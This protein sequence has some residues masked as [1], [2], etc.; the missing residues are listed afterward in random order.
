MDNNTYAEIIQH[1]CGQVGV[2]PTNTIIRNITTYCKKLDIRRLRNLH[3]EKTDFVI[4][5]AESY[6]N[7]LK[8]P[9]VKQVDTQ[10]YHHTTE[11]KPV[12]EVSPAWLQTNMPITASKTMGL[13]FDTVMRGT[14]N[15]NTTITNFEFSLVS[16]SQISNGSNGFIQTHVLPSQITYFKISPFTIPYTNTMRAMNFAKEI[17]LT[18]NTLASNGIISNNQTFHFIFKYTIIDNALVELTPVNQYYKFSPPLRH[19][20]NLSLHMSDPVV[21]ITFAM[22]RMPVSSLNY[23]SADGRI[24]FAQAH[25]LTTGDVIIVQGLTT[26][27]DSANANVLAQINNPR[28]IVITVINPTIVS[29]GIDFT[30]IITPDT[31][32]KPIVLFYS[33]TFRFSMEIGYQDIDELN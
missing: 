25:N 2:E 17:T 19:L 28:G 21:P 27:D 13:Y 18:F 20:D 24:T 22:D 30:T 9:E 8:K 10:G 15:D 33:K 7:S 23:I 5:V 12:K 26:L 6:I 32:S 1:V 4:T 3:P 31:N 11:Y 14:Y 29:T 16:R